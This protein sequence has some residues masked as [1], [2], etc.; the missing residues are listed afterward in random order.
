MKLGILFVFL[1]GV[2]GL[3]D[4]MIIPIIPTQRAM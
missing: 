1:V 4:V 2:L 3:Q